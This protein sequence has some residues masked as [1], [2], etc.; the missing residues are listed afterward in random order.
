MRFHWFAEATYPDLPPEFK[1][2]G[3]S[4][5][6]DTPRRYADPAKQGAALNGFLELYRLTI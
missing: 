1:T 2:S 6:V 5:W 3:S 4:I